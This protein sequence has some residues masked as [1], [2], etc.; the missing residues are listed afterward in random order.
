M[1]PQRFMRLI[2][3]FGSC[4]PAAR[5]GVLGRV[6]CG[7]Y[8]RRIPIWLA[9]S[10]SF[11]GL[12][13]MAASCLWLDKSQPFP[14]GAL[15]CRCW[16]RCWWWLPARPLW[17]N[18]YVLGN[19]LMVGIGLISF[20]LY[21]WH[22]PL[23]AFARVLSNGTPDRLA[24]A[25]AVAVAMLLAWLTYELLEN[26]CVIATRGLPRSGFCWRCLWRWLHG[27]GPECSAGC[28]LVTA[29]LICSACWR[30]AGTRVTPA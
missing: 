17:L 16:G 27:V 26:P 22:W 8:V 9:N 30:P 2:R 20:P 12:A 28:R 1:P 6:A 4:W 21:L 5:A 3:A 25:L 13:L 24:R 29:I 23:L 19:R 7:N 10:L 11:A 14:G 15:L 18:R